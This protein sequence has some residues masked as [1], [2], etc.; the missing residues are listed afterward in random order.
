MFFSPEMM[1]VFQYSATMSAMQ[2]ARNTSQLA[3]AEQ[4]QVAA[5]QQQL[6]KEKA[7]TRESQERME[8]D[9]KKHNDKMYRLAQEEI[10]LQRRREIHAS[11]FRSLAVFAQ[12]FVEKVHQVV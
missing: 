9:Q 4:Q 3:N 10:K 8:A 1:Q 11:E 12:S 7:R 5:E 6:A 2:T